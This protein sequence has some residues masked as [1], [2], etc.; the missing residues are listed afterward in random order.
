MSFSSST[1]WEVRTTGDDTN[2]GGYSSGGVDYSQQDSPQVSLTDMVIDGTTNTIFSSATLGSNSNYIGN[3]INVTGGTGF[4]VQRV[5]IV[6]RSGANYTVDKSLG[7]L[8]STGGT[9]NL[10]GA[11]A[12]PGQAGAVFVDGNTIFIKYNASAYSIT[13]SSANV[14][15]GKL[16]IS[17]SGNSSI[18]PKVIG[19]DTTRTV[20]NTDSNRPTLQVSGAIS[21][22]TV[23]AFSSSVSGLIRNIIV[24]GASKSSMTGISS[25][26][27]FGQTLIHNCK[28]VNCTTAG[29]TGSGLTN[30]TNCEAD[31]C[32]IGFNNV[33]IH[34]GCYAHNCTSHGFAGATNSVIGAINCISASNGGSGFFGTSGTGSTSYYNC[35]AYNNTG[36]GFNVAQSFTRGCVIVNCISVNNGGWGFK[37]D[38]GYPTTDLINCAGGSGTTANTSGNYTSAN[39]P[40]V[41]N[42]VTTSAAPF[43]NAGSGDFSL[44]N[45]AGGGAACRAAGFPGVF[46][47]GLTTGY[48]DIGAVQHQ[49]SGGGGSSSPYIIGS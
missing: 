17:V 34:F 7:T 6:S 31:S 13:S 2:G 4:T 23:V 40:V 1:V 19:Y 22:F 14:S 24:D 39:H 37:S 46:P 11:F 16:S 47:G 45:T 3:I 30:A 38:S 12:S 25:S 49:D 44:N 42:F 8:G 21:S 48:L 9:G 36:D 10:G 32:A 43:T 28:I 20:S 15:G 18:L 29:L 26:S 27:S 35:T 33:N 5:Q 41:L